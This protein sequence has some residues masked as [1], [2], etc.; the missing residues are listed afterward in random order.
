M[1]NN[2]TYSKYNMTFDILPYDIS[3]VKF[4]FNDW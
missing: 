3:C 1:I 2:Y 4:E